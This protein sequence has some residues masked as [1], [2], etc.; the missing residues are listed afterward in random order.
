MGCIISSAAC[1]VGSAACGCIS[2]CCPTCRSSTTSRLMYSGILLLAVL[3]S[4][5]IRIPGLSDTLTKIPYLC[6]NYTSGSNIIPLPDM[7]GDLDC[8]L[9]ASYAFV[10][11][12][13]F[14][15]TI[16]FFLMSLIMIG[17]RSSKDIRG[18][19]QNGFWLWKY[20][21]V[22]AGTI[23]AMFMPGGF[24]Y[25]W[26][27]IA[28]IGAFVFILIQLMLLVD[29]AHTWNETWLDNAETKDPSWKCGIV[30]FSLF[31]FIAVIAASVL[32][33]VYYCGC[34]S[35]GLNIAL[36]TMNIV[37]SIAL[38][39]VAILPGVQ[40]HNPHSGLL[41][42]SVISLYCTYLL[43]T[44]LSSD[45]G[46][47]NPVSGGDLGTAIVGILITFFA[48]IWSVLQT[49][50]SNYAS[51]LG[52]SE[53]GALLGCGGYQDGGTEEVEEG[54]PRVYDN[55]EE[56]VAYSYSFFHFMFTLATLYLMLVLTDWYS[57]KSTGS[58]VTEFTYTT[59]TAM[60][61]KIT[62]SWICYLLYGWTLVAP[63]MFPDRDFGY[64]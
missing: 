21:I 63:A 55:E 12:V 64:S 15:V 35:N 20:L 32:L 45:T 16:F 24:E 23:G 4:L 39:V 56:G 48:V 40:E 26:M 27:I 8:T 47:C 30:F 17:V 25:A 11:R 29:F 19:I 44:G 36:I 28:Y 41:Q 10:Y 58:T 6:R 50:S 18:P 33:Y 61:V 52:V 49:S 3:V 62:T 7:K 59:K 53:E 31:N 60:W 2:S 34:A 43:W 37:L 42:S 57:P 5:I 13:C 38:S 22:I 14:A 46:D 51:K 1:C 54:K 9:I